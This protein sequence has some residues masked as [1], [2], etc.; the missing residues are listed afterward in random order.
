M[1]DNGPGFPATKA[2]T[3]GI[4]LANTRARLQQLY[5]DGGSLTVENG[6]EC[7]ATVTMTLPFCLAAEGE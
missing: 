4:G 6:T 5:G 7:G 1:R 2:E 3:T